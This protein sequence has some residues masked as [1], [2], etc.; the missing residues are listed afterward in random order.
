MHDH[1]ERTG[2]WTATLALALALGRAAYAACGDGIVDPDEQCDQGADNGRSC[3]EVSCMPKSCDDAEE[4]TVDTCVYNA[5]RHRGDCH[6]DALPNQTPCTS[7][8]NPCTRDA[9]NS[10]GGC[11]HTALAVPEQDCDGNP[12][13]VPICSDG[14]CLETGRSCDDANACTDD[15]CNPTTGACTFTPRPNG[16][17]CA[18]GDACHEPSR[19]M[20]AQCTAG[21]A[22]VCPDD[23]KPCTVATCTVSGGGCRH[24]NVDDD[25]PCPDDGV[26]CTDD[27][28]DK[29]QCEHPAVHGR[30]CS[31]SV[32]QPLGI[33][34]ADGTCGFP[35]GTEPCRPPNPCQ[36]DGIACDDG[37]P[38]T[39]QSSCV[40][41][42]CHGTCPEPCATDG[43]A[44]VDFELCTPTSACEGGVCVGSG[45]AVGQGCPEPCGLY[46]RLQGDGTCV[47]AQ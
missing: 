20:D 17:W 40:S 18:A 16:T 27:L 37:S 7:D 13:T 6:H 32:C 36:T 33:C 2:S 34:G 30:S 12:C 15:A 1:H 31:T 35:A 26:S 46:C 14:I 9:C 25:M 45:C 23:G 38:C 47:C 42:F 10:Q 3:C 21:V 4:C 22:I 43:V 28:C 11:R 24:M 19:C 44:C 8:G 41:G 29:G 5:S 39:T